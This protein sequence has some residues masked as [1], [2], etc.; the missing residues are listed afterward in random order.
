MDWHDVCLAW[1]QRTGASKINIST[2]ACKSNQE[3]YCYRKYS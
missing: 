3:Y 2:R 1:S